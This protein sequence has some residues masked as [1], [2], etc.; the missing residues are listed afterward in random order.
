MTGVQTCALPIY[1]IFAEADSLINT[2]RVLIINDGILGY[3]PFDILLYEKMDKNYS[4]KDLPYLIKK[5]SIGYAYSFNI[6][7]KSEKGDNIISNFLG[8]APFSK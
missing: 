2:K 1:T 3:I 7:G 4:Y 6:L 5:Y 8:I